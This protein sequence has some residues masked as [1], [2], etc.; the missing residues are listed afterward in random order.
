MPQAIAVT[1]RLAQYVLH[2][3]VGLHYIDI[4][5]FL[6]QA[7]ADMKYYAVGCEGRGGG[8]CCPGLKCVKEEGSDSGTCA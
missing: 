7:E 4:V 2:V 1:L 5:L 6:L 3:E 8:E